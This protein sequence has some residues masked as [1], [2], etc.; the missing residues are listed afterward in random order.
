[1]KYL[2]LLYLTISS[3]GLLTSCFHSGSENSSSESIPPNIIVFMVDDMGWMDTSVP[4][5]DDPMPLNERYHTPYME[6]LAKAGM[7][8]K[9]AYAQPVCTPTRVS[10]L[11]GMNAARAHVTNWI[12]PHKNTPT[13]AKDPQFDPINWNMNGLSTD[14]ETENTIH[15]TPLPALL[16]ENGYHT[17]HIGK[18]HW[19]SEGTPGSDP[20]N[21]GFMKNIAGHAGGHPQ[22]YLSDDRFGNIPGKAQPQAVPDLEKYYD[23]NIFL[24]EALTREAIQAIET[25]ITEKK[26][27]F[28]NMSHYALHTPIMADERFVQKYYDQGIDS[29]EAKYASLI[30]GMDK[31]LGDLMEYLE[32]ND[33]TD[34]TV[35]LFISDNGGLDHH[36]RAGPVNTHNHPLRSGK[37]SIYEGGIRVPMIVKWPGV[38]KEDTSTETPVIIEDFFLSILDIAGID[39]PNIMQEIDAMS[40]VPLLKNPEHSTPERPLVFH[41]PHNWIPISPDEDLGINYYSAVRMGDWKLIYRM[42][43]Q[44]FQLY[45]IVQD[46][47]EKTDLKQQY[48]D[49]VIKLAQILGETLKT[50][51]AQMPTDK[52]TGHSVPFPDEVVITFELHQQESN[53]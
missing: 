24:T 35:I 22:S 15:A 33:Q 52:E 16:Q 11:T 45:N 1:M 44:S 26:P 29:I 46:I 23:Q 20:L 49:K 31:S 7:K 18:A 43:D 39:S 36:Q 28:L 27:F 50:R 8:F 10:F 41:Y 37:G 53:E 3:I 13:D 34:R 47:E 9:H 4:F 2:N 40:F 25:P 21:L 5:Y 42:R 51:N 32:E 12:S 38:V 17:I 6:S 19:G 48:P 14:P 30:E